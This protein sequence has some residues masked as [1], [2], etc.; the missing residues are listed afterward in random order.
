MKVHVGLEPEVLL[1]GYKE[2]ENYLI[3]SHF[4]LQ[5]LHNQ[6]SAFAAQ[7]VDF[8]RNTVKPNLDMLFWSPIVRIN[9]KEL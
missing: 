9:V 2:I 4:I 7:T 3:K 1:H 8:V 6:N 5:P